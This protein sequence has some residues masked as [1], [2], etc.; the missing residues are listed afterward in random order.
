VTRAAELAGRFL[1]LAPLCLAGC[2]GSTTAEGDG[3]ADLSASQNPP[4]PQ[5]GAE[6]DR[7]G[8]P[9]VNTALTD[10]FDTLI[11]MTPDQIKDA[12]NAEDDEAKWAAKFTQL[13]AANL[14]IFD[15][16][17][18]HGPANGYGCGNQ[19]GAASG[20][21]GGTR[22]A[23]LAGA[24]ADDELYLDTTQ[25]SCG[26]YLAVEANTLL[27]LGLKDCG[28]RT[29]TMDAIDVTYSALA[30]GALTGMTDGVAQP[31]PR[32]SNTVFPF[33]GPPQ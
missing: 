30:Q 21:D 16:L 32:P 6:I 15:G 22:Y 7:V 11:G 9:A 25:T 3:G 23:A 27:S 10:P 2:G 29:P 5:L 31:D 28:G 33:L 20:N 14:A 17:D 13:I 19:L 4:P 18:S 12:Y 24:L 26:Q 8:R 1:F